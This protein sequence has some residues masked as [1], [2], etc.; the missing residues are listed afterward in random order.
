MAMHGIPVIFQTSINL[1]YFRNPYRIKFWPVPLLFLCKNCESP[2]QMMISWLTLTSC[3]GLVVVYQTL[4]SLTWML[5]NNIE[6]CE[7]SIFRTIH[8]FIL[9]GGV[10]YDDFFIFRKLAV[11]FEFLFQMGQ[12]ILKWRLF[13]FQ[14]IRK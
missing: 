10:A 9:I 13:I 14:P 4:C 5:I 7:E 6:Q 11:I 3:N 8:N 1:L 2:T 12:L